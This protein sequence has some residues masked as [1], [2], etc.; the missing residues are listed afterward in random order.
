MVL[1][2][3]LIL[4]LVTHYTVLCTDPEIEDEEIR[5]RDYLQLLNQKTQE[6]ENRLALAEWAYAS[7]LT[8]ANLRNKVSSF[9]DLNVFLYFLI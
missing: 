9:Y 5:A 3:L 6:Q 1:K 8:E 2:F 4:L 7:N